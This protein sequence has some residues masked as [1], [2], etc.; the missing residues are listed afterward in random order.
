LVCCLFWA[1]GSWETSHAK[2]AFWPPCFYLKA[3]YNVLVWKMPFR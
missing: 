2:R 1:A 3:G